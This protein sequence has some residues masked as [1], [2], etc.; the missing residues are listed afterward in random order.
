MRHGSCWAATTTTPPL[1]LSQ[2]SR[3]IRG[4][5]GTVSLSPWPAES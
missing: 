5:E 2:P 3:S 4:A 1:C